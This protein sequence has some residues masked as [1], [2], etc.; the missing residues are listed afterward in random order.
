MRLYFLLPLSA[1]LF[2][3][4]PL[5]A[6][7]T[8]PA[9]NPKQLVA[10][11]KRAYMNRDLSTAQEKFQRVQELEPGNLTAQQYL[12][13]IEIMEEKSSAGTPFEKA[14]KTVTLAKVDF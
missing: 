12:R 8:P 14:L 2:V 11:G 7:T 6:Q 5:H 13:A 3:A 1:L 10:E 9:Q 4:N